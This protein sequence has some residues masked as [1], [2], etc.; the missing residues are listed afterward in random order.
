MLIYRPKTKKER[1]QN[2]VKAIS[3]FLDNRPTKYYALSFEKTTNNFEIFKKEFEQNGYMTVYGG[4][5]EKSIYES[6]VTN[7]FGRVWHDEIHLKHDL[8]FSL[9]SEK[10]VA[11]YQITEL[12]LFLA[13]ECYSLETILDA[14]EVLYRD[15]V[16]QVEYYYEKGDFVENQKEFVYSRFLS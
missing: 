2:A 3:D 7:I 9:E 16:G 8:D 11:Q 13:N 12:E 6:E 5:C 4:A 14:K 15:I 1:F 10:T